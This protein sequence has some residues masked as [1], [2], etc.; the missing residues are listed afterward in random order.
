MP[1]TPFNGLALP[2]ALLARAAAPQPDPEEEALIVQHLLADDHPMMLAPPAAPDQQEPAV[3]PERVFPIMRPEVR[4][5][6]DYPMPNVSR[7]R[8]DRGAAAVPKQ[9]SGDPIVKPGD[10]DYLNPDLHRYDLIVP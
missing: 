10:A 2:P 7:Y 4:P 5:A 9:Q 8:A 3:A 6:A 1:A